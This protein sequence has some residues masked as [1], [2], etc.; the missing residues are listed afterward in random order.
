MSKAAA[1]I[2]LLILTTATGC[3]VGIP[4]DANMR[5][6]IDDPKLSKYSQNGRD[7]D[8]DDMSKKLG[9]E[10]E[11]GEYIK[12]SRRAA[13]GS[14][15]AFVLGSGVAVVPIVSFLS[16]D[17]ELHWSGVSGSLTLFTLGIVLLGVQEVY[18]EKAARAHNDT[19][20]QRNREKQARHQRIA[21]KQAVESLPKLPEGFGFAFNAGAAEAE[22]V[23]KSNGYEWTVAESVFSC[24]GIPMTGAPQGSSE[25]TFADGKMQTLRISVR[26]RNNARDWSTVISEIEQVVTRMYGEPKEKNYTIPS[27]CVGSAF[28]GCIT[29]GR[30]KGRAVWS[31]KKKRSVT[32][33]IVNTSPHPW[34]VVDVKRVV[35]KAEEQ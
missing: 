12:K 7:L 1:A 25:L 19:V 22:S 5:I 29:D 26:P 13:V 21:A 16:N 4:L 32:M 35:V 10:V 18:V 20:D 27:E 2:T 34:I 23:C 24:S 9:D 28:L 8:P 31:G 15:I 33:A 17:K 3:T 30:I 14:A 11:A 6:A